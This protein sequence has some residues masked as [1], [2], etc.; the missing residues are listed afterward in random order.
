M[1]IAV[2]VL[3]PAAR[4]QIDSVA[5]PDEVKLGKGLANTIDLV[6]GTAGV[7][8]T[9][10][11]FSSEPDNANPQ[12]AD[13]LDNNYSISDHSNH[14][15]FPGYDDCDH[16]RNVFDDGWAAHHSLSADYSDARHDREAILALVREHWE[17]QGYEVDASSE[18]QGS[19]T[20]RRLWIDSD[21]GQINFIIDPRHAI[22]RIVGITDCLPP[23]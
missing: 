10:L 12:L 22:A 7:V 4:A 16:A 23:D 18:Q 19:Y 6:H 8:D 1:L 13:E 15:H 3:V 17:S 9:Q 2:V 21:F 11:E 14:Q 20:Y 5:F